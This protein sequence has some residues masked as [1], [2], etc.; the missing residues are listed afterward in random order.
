MAD[1]FMG[2]EFTAVLRGVQLL[3]VR[4]AQESGTLR[5][6]GALL[7]C[8]DVGIGVRFAQESGTLRLGGAARRESGFT[9]FRRRDTGIGGASRRDSRIPHHDS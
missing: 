4:F 1:S 7:R 2:G 3:N 5:S 6:G 9:S 8:R